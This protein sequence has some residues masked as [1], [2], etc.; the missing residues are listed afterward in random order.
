M[1]MMLLQAAQLSKATHTV[2]FKRY[3]PPA[4]EQAYRLLLTRSNA[5]L[6]RLKAKIKPGN[7]VENDWLKALSDVGDLAATVSVY[8]DT[9]RFRRV[10]HQWLD[11]WR[12]RASLEAQDPDIRL[13]RP[14]DYRF[15]AYLETTLASLDTIIR[16]AGK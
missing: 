13:G 16:G 9:G 5:S 2:G 12:M 1:A 10:A 11:L 4:D 15:A 8:D 3:A 6:R 7:D 14:E